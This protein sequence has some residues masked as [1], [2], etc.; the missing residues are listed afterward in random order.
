M[1]HSSRSSRK[2]TIHKQVFIKHKTSAVITAVFIFLLI[3]LLLAESR[4][5]YIYGDGGVVA[6]ETAVA[7]CGSYILSATQA[8]V[9]STG[10]SG[11]VIVYGG[12]A[13]GCV[14]AA[15]VASGASSWISITSSSGDRNVTYNVVA[16]NGP[17][18]AGIITIA[19]VAFTINQDSG[20]TYSISP[21][22]SG[23]IGVY[24]GNGNFTVTANN[25]MC[26]WTASKPSWVTITSGASG[27]GTGT[28]AY[29]VGSNSESTR[30]GSITVGGKIHTVKQTS[31]YCTQY[32]APIQATCNLQ[33]QACISQCI[34]QAPPGCSNNPGAC[35]EALQACAAGC[36]S[37][38]LAACGVTYTNCLSTCQ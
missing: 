11:N 10:G 34:S 2:N 21:T 6:V 12:D 19:G 32:C 30:S 24:G 13:Y 29:S 20:C 37:Q 3:P 35:A 14:W 4:K 28:V 36:Q 8:S 5:E 25:N 27:T 7:G 33:I 17:A 31:E 16:N 15:T 23:I 26:P 9:V 18:R 38:G 22:Y 1:T